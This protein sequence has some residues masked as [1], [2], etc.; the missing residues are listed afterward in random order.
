M[1]AMPYVPDEYWRALHRR[2]DLSAV[3]Q[4][5][6]PAQLNEWLY[7]A[8]ARNLRAFVR[9]HRLDRPAPERVFDVGSGTGY[10]VRFWHERGVTRVDGCDLVPEA[11][12][13]LQ[14]AF[15]ARGDRFV[16][17]DIVDGSTLPV[18]PYPLVSVMNVLL[19][20]TDDAAFRRASAAIARLVAPGGHLLL[21]EPILLHE[22]FARP[23]TPDQHSRARPLAAYRD[24]LVAA[25][26]E[27][28][29]VRAAVALANNP[30]EA[31]SPEAYRRYV[32]WWRWVAGTAKRDPRSGGWLGP[33]VV[34]A[35]RLAMAA[36]AAPSSKFALFRRRGRG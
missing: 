5:A 2:R 7:R 9:R 31:G 20:V 26:L 29:D 15:G 1:A 34:A 22:A 33:L 14:Q 4:A 28:V 25:G 18:H 10:W 11:V 24:P 6:L 32:G 27:L 19:H 30:I 23:A 13:R 3:G 16:T 12:D 36:G 8:L 21:A 17:A 35:D